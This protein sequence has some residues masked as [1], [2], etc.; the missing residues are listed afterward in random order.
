MIKST[1]MKSF[2]LMLL[3]ITLL[4]EDAVVLPLTEQEHQ[5][6]VLLWENLQNAQKRE[7]AANAEWH[8]FLSDFGDAH[9]RDSKKIMDYMPWA[10]KPEYKEGWRSGFDLDKT[11]RYAVANRE[12]PAWYSYYVN[13]TPG[14]SATSSATN[15][16][17][18][19]SKRNIPKK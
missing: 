5:K 12:Q 19:K 10:S 9:L 11:F 8:R 17:T 2:V 14:S 7:Y 16:K 15:N 1:V 3:A 13:T 6:A 4:A 18:S